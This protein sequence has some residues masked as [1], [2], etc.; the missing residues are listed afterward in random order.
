MIVA[1]MDWSLSCPAICIYDT[2]KPLTFKNCKFFFLT[3]KNKQV[4]NFGN[5]HGFAMQEYKSVEERVDNISEWGITVLKTANAKR[6][7]I[8]GYAMGAKGQVFTIAENGGLIKHK[9]YKAGIE[10]ITPAPTSV[11]KLFTG[12]GNANKEIMYNSAM[13]IDPTTPDVKTLYG[14]AIDGN[15]TSDIIDSFAMVHYLLNEMKQE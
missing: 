6:A 2:S 12:K 1:G 7:C 11:K 13:S 14:W 5:I 9:M 3:N 15:P 10:F 8:E 4:G